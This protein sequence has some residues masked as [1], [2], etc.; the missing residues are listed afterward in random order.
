MKKFLA[1][2]ICTLGFATSAQAAFI[3]ASW[4]ETLTFNG[5]KYIGG[6]A[7]YPYTHDLGDN[8]FRPLTDVIT[9]FALTINLKDDQ[10]Y[11]ATETAWVNL[12]GITGDSFVY[13]FGLSGSEYG[14]WSIAGL[15]ELNLLGTLSVTIKSITGDFILQSSH[16]AANGYANVPEPGALAL[17]GIGL[18]GM[19]L[20]MRRRKSAPLA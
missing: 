17:L 3:P 16:L 4:S 9:D 12:P 8:G 19:A 14:G 5:G 13:N 7:S 1:L 2:L 15:F 10:G 18:L 6:G 20:S 11:D